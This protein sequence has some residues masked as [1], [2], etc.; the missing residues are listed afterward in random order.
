MHP[1]AT[2][3]T[4]HTGPHP[5]PTLLAVTAALPA[6]AVATWWAVG[7]L[8][9]PEG[10]IDPTAAGAL[11]TVAHRVATASTGVVAAAG[12]PTAEGT[13]AART[14]PGALT[15]TGPRRVR[16]TPLPVPGDLRELTRGP[17]RRPGDDVTAR[18]LVT[19]FRTGG[20]T[21]MPSSAVKCPA[22]STT[23]ARVPSRAAR[24]SVAVVGT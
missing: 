3:P 13:P 15:P 7:D 2:P 10:W 12:S 20:R 21:V 17:P 18:Q 11:L 5:V 9:H 24:S 6:T 19:V 23:C 4:H 1:T 8:S 22:P 16:G 14:A